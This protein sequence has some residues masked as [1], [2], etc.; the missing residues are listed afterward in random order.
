MDEY[1][2]RLALEEAEKAYKIGEVPIGAVI[3]RN[4]EVVSKAY[5]LRERDKNATAH[6]EVLAIQ[7]ACENLGGWR[8]TN[9]TIYVTIE[10]C[11]MCAGAILQSRI[12]RLVIG[13]M[14]YKAG[15]CGSLVN[16]LNDERFNHQTEIITGVLEEEA[17]LLMKNF[18]RE[19]RKK[20]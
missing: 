2:M 14:D 1:Y 4:G 3:V 15:A 5:N 13:A 9:S 18:F 17:S 8:L 6:A 16:L 20:K 7:K 10:P 19:L 11:P 12:D